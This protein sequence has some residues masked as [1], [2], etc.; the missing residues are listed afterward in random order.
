MIYL[1]IRVKTR[2]DRTSV[3]TV[4]AHLFNAGQCESALLVISHMCFHQ[5]QFHYEADF[6]P[7]PSTQ[8][9]PRCL[10]ASL[11][12]LIIYSQPPNRGTA[13]RVI[14][15]YGHASAPQALCTLSSLLSM[16]HPLHQPFHPGKWFLL[17]LREPGEQGHHQ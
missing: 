14:T 7:L 5:P 4:L 3:S 16:P 12:R 17:P 13:R 8:L 9:P 15:V 6:L 11:P 1:L 2:S 10:A